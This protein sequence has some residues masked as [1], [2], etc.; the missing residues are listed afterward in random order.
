VPDA[1]RP[2]DDLF[3]H[4][5]GTWYD[6][7]EIPADLPAIGG[8]TDLFLAAEATVGEILRE[9]AQ[10]AA[11]GAVAPGTDRQKMG[12]LFASFMAEDHVEGLG[13][14]PL[15]EDLAAIAALTDMGELAE[16]LGRFQ[17][18]NVGGVLDCYVHIDDR[19]SDR[20]IVNLVQGGLGMPDESFYRD[21]A[22]AEH[23]EKYVAHVAAMLRLVGQSSAQAEDGAS[24]VMALETRLAAAHWDKVRSRDVVATYNL[25]TLDDLRTA[26]PAF[27]WVR[28]IA[29]IGGTE[30]QFAEALVRQPSYLPAMSAAVTDVPLADWQTWLTYHVVRT[31]APYL[32]SAF[33]NEHFD[34]YLR[35][36]TGAEALR[37]RWKRGVALCNTAIGEAVGAEYVARVL[38][39]DAKSEMDELVANLLAAYRVSIDRL[40][41]MSAETRN[42]ALAKLDQFRSKIGHPSTWRDYSALEIDRDDLLGNVRR[43]AAFEVDRQLRKIGAPV[44]RDEWLL[45]PQTVNAYYLPTANEI[46]FPAAI[47]R[48]PFF[49]AGADP[50]LNY[51]GI[52]AVIGHEIGHGFDDQGSRYDGDG[53]LVN[54]W[55]DEDRARFQERAD[56]LIEQ[57]N[58]F[59]PRS[60]PGHQVNGALTVGENIGDLGGLTIA[61]LAYEISL[62]GEDPPMIGGLTGRQR[63]IQ[64]WALIWRIKTRPELALQRLSVDPHA[65]PEFRANVVRNLDEF[66]AAYATA[67]GDGLWL[68]PAE[69]VRIW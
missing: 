49:Q 48:P 68:D 30:D 59:E 19:N 31:A 22:F 38:P 47:L 33:V 32:S 51:G 16:L 67:P 43:A 54:W 44:D 25:T 45:T 69:R 14:E 58:G 64:N 3:G 65:P 12:D 10:D 15:A 18:H 39:P 23:R 66:H 52:G 1:I 34:F 40:D 46:C 50:A 4:V 9:A 42:R 24:R 11:S 26:A 2:Q 55:T 36:L 20:N 13:H 53:N 5:N 17:R 62:A 37:D 41:W 35:T 7:A 6:T 63:L 29:G 28:W 8:F 56:R 27:D 60:M 21:D 57:Y 61:L